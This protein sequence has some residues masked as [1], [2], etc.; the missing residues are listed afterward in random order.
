MEAIGK[1]IK[2]GTLLVTTDAAATA[3]RGA[4]RTSW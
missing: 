3:E 1:R 4:A 2:P